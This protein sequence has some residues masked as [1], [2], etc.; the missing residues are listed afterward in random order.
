MIKAKTNTGDLLFGI[1]AENVRRLKNGHPI[2]I[3]MAELGGRAGTFA[4]IMYGETLAD[5]VKEIETAT[6]QSFDATV[7]K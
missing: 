1:D 7:K 2:V 4:I 5:I 3:D 6:G